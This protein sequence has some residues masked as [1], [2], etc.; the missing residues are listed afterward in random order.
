MFQ[1]II[2]KSSKANK[3]RLNDYTHITP[4]TDLDKYY[5]LNY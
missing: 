2:D 1:H 5:T 4:Q 3:R